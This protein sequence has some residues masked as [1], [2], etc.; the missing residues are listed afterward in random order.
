[1]KVGT[2]TSPYKQH[3]KRLVPVTQGVLT[4]CQPMMKHSAWA[5][6]WNDYAWAMYYLKLG[7]GL[8]FSCSSTDIETLVSLNEDGYV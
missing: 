7:R 4:K 8:L 2:M 1:M 3:H 6:L 5:F